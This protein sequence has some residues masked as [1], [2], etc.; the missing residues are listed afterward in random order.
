MVVCFTWSLSKRQCGSDTTRG[1][2]SSVGISTGCGQGLPP[3]PLGD[4]CYVDPQTG[5]GI[6]SRPAQECGQ[7]LPQCPQG[8]RCYVDSQ[9]Q[10]YCA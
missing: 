9:G 7:G 6:C 2:T 3:C 10:G 1:I 8:K 4:T 5:M